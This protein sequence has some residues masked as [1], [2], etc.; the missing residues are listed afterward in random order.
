MRKTLLVLG[1]ALAAVAVPVVA[2]QALG[3]PLPSSARDL[4][5]PDPTI[6]G[7]QTLHC[8]YGPLTVTPGANLILL[9]PVSIESPR[10]SGYI[11]SISPNLVDA[12][13]GM[14]PPIHVVHLHHGVWINAARGTT[15]PFFATGEEKTRSILP[16]GPNGAPQYGYR[17]EPGDAWVLNYMLHNLTPNT[18]EVTIRYDLTWVPAS[19]PGMKEVVPVWLDAVGREEGSD[20]AL[21]PVY[22]PAKDGSGYSATFGAKQDAEIVW[23]GGHVHPGGLRDELRSVECDG[24]LLFSSEARMNGPNSFGSWDFGMTVTPP[25]WRFTVR[26]GDELSVTGYYDTEH[27][28][29]EAMAIMFAWA[30]PLSDAEMASRPPC[31]MPSATS[32][33]PTAAPSAPENNPAPFFGGAGETALAPSA[34]PPAPTTEVRIA[35]FNYYPGGGTGARAGVRRGQTVRFTNLDAGASIFHSVTSCANPCNGE[36]GQR[37]PLA[38]WPSETQLGDSGQLGFGPPFA[39]AA[40]QRATWSFTVPSSAPVGEVFTY[41]CRIHPVMRGAL[42]VVP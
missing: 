12:T 31:A 22:D 25:D 27:P 6:A 10:A 15:D 19:T 29:Y 9:G 33:A 21:Y 41:F 17:T 30:H 38:T 23:V 18:Y 7:E 40:V 4:C 26:Q 1:L 5:Q 36:W 16:R 39:T 34:P 11:T 35:A 3:P 14:V 24:A 8:R 28:W 20:T 42:E 2:A 13:T 32:G 37:Y